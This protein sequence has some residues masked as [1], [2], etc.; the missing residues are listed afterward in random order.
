VFLVS[1]F[2]FLIST[3]RNCLFGGVIVLNYACG[4]PDALFS[5]PYLGGSDIEQ[6]SISIDTLHLTLDENSYYGIFRVIKD[7]IVFLDERYLTASVFDVEGELWNTYLGEGDGPEEIENFY[8]HTYLSSG[9]H[10]F[11][12][13]DYFFSYYDSKWRKS[14]QP[15]TLQWRNRKVRYRGKDLSLIE[16]YDINP[17]NN[18]FDTRWNPVWKNEYLVVPI[19]ITAKT[20]PESNR[21][22]NAEYYFSNAFTVGLVDFT[23]GMFEI[24]LGKYPAPYLQNRYIPAFDY[25][26]REV[27]NDTLYVSYMADSLIYA[28]NANLD[29]IFTFG[30]ST[31]K[32]RPK[33]TATTTQEEYAKLTS[34]SRNESG[35]YSHIFCDKERN[36]IFRSFVLPNQKEGGLQV[37][38]DFKL[39]AEIIT[40]PRFNVIGQLDGFY[41]VDGLID[42]KMELFGVYLLELNRTFDAQ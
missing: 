41:V 38:K 20:N 9:E 22:T 14:K 23:T 3:I 5:T 13:D 16:K 30:N 39:V 24:G 1:P 33:Y 37:Y 27:K 19:N 21:F 36:L 28:Y 42:E 10:L 11:L 2:Q 26:Y 4:K 34:T 29:L 12:G 25:N 40:P 31:D 32:V 7:S 18:S 17:E 8:Y 6:V 35:Y 15:Q